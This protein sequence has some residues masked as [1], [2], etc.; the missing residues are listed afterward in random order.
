MDNTHTRAAWCLLAV[1]LLFVLWMNVCFSFSSDD[2]SYALMN[3]ADANGVRQPLTSLSQILP[4]TIADGW[5]PVVH[6]FVR[7]FTG[8][9][10]KTAF[11]V[12]NT[13]M[14]GAL[15]LL[16]YRLARGFLKLAFSS[17][18]LLI[19]LTLFVLCKGESYLWCAGSLNYLWAGTGTLAFFALVML[20]EQSRIRLWLTPLLMIAALFAGMLQESFSVPMAFALG[21]YSLIHIRSLSVQKVLVYGCYGLGILVLAL[22]GTA[23]GRLGDAGFSLTILLG[24]MVK[25]AV[26][27]K[28]AWVLLLLLCFRRDR[29]E[30]IRRNQLELLAVVGSLLLIC[31]VGFNGER[32]LWCANLFAILVVVREWAPPR[33]VGAALALIPIPVYFVTAVLGYKIKQQFE[34][35]DRLYM[36]SPEGITC[37]ERVDCGPFARFF[38]QV[39]YTWQTAT[40]HNRAYGFYRGHRCPPL[41]LQRE[42]YDNL[43]LVDN[44]CV[45]ENRIA[46]AAGPMF[47]TPTA[48]AIVMPMG[49][50]DTTDWD[51]VRV[52]VR[53]ALPDSFGEWV[54][55][56]LAARRSPPI[57]EPHRPVVLKTPHGDYLLI[58]KQPECDAYIQSIEFRSVTKPTTH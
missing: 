19:A 32:S 26:A 37:H 29:F 44:F 27:V 48:N 21:I 51:A 42:L 18:A 45:S 41:A 39:V 46:V 52:S 25:V 15:L 4:E 8:I 30:I 28:A 31:G 22:H 49:A 34:S 6:F 38:H 57:P 23:A 5:R 9:L 2:C 50:S 55:R 24:T 17:T 11:N 54:R 43:Y 13:V 58:A 12:A 1:F 47:T 40:G 20:L 3:V 33:W 16:V 10:G 36:A 14:M 56:E 53:Y 7:L 35:F